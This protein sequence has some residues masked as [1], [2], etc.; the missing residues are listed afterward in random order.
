MQDRIGSWRITFADAVPRDALA[1]LFD[2]RGLAPADAERIKSS[3]V[4]EVLQ[5]ALADDCRVFVKRYRARGA[6]DALRAL[7]GGSRA[8]QEFRNLKRACAMGLPT[9]E[10]LCCA[11]QR[12]GGVPTESVLVTRALADARVLGDLLPELG[13]GARAALLRRLGGVAR[14]LHDSGLWHRDFHLGNVLCTPSDDP[15][16]VLVDLQKLR[17]LRVSLP[18]RLR[19]RDLSGLA[20]GLN[21]ADGAI[22]LEC[23]ARAAAPELDLAALH[24]RLAADVERRAARRLRSRGRRCV[25]HSSGFRVE[26]GLSHALFRRADVEPSAVRAAIDVHR[27]GGGVLTRVDDV[28]GGPP[29]GAP[30]DPFARGHGGAEP[31]APARAAVH[32]RELRERG[33]T[34]RGRGM[35]AWRAAHAVLLRGFDTPAPLALLEQRRLG[36]VRRSWLLTRCEDELRPLAEALKNSGDPPALTRAAARLLGRMHAAGLEYRVQPADRLLA[37]ADGGRVLLSA[38]EDLLVSTPSRVAKR[39]VDLAQLAR[40][41]REQRPEL[42]SELQELLSDYRDGSEAADSAWRALSASNSS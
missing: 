3:P 31:G 25:V 19:V 11:E 12:R 40:T 17:W 36:F 38:L 41:I 6:L 5:V 9:V 32:V 26:Q 4:R 23:Y 20:S 14:R 13:A 24:S 7:A 16:P 1:S 2:S 22:L 15:E 18:L 37:R 34:L 28:A 27:R 39:S 35:R 8:Q 42:A 30:P 29:A 33:L 10:P 21:A